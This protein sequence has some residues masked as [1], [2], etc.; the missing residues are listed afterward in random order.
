VPTCSH[1][2][3]RMRSSN[4]LLAVRPYFPYRNT[5]HQA[6]LWPA[7]VLKTVHENFN[8]V[9]FDMSTSA[10][11]HDSLLYG[12][13]FRD[14]IGTINRPQGHSIEPA[15]FAILN[16]PNIQSVQVTT[17]LYQQS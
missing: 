16:A 17:A 7:P 2:F 1:Q 8:C 10:Q 14:Q 3:T 11:I 5:A 6:T 9:P 12:N 13:H 4:H 15:G